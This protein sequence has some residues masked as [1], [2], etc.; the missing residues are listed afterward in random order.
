LTFYNAVTAIY[1][2]W[3][4]GWTYK[5]IN[6]I[7]CSV[8]LNMSNGGHT[9]QS[10]NSVTFIDSS[11]TNTPV[12]I[13]TAFDATSLPPTSGS[14]IIENV[15]LN[16]VPIAIQGPGSA[17]VLSGST[18][19][20]TIAAWGQGHAYTPTGPT[21]FEG[22]V[23][24][25]PRPDS[26]LAGNKF[27][28]R[29][30]PQYAEVPVSQFLSVRDYGATGDG[31]TD[32]SEALNAILVTAAM[33]GKIV[34]FDAGIY[35]VKSTVGVPAGSRIVGES[36]PLI[37]GAGAFFSDMNNPQP[38]V[39]VGQ[40]GGESGDAVEW[41]D[42]IVAT[43]GATA[44]AVLIEWNL[45]ACESVPSGMWDVHTRIGGF[46]GSDLQ[47]TQ[48]QNTPSQNV[49]S[50]AA[51]NA[52]C[53]AAFMSMHVTKGAARL[54]LE[55]VWLWTADHDIDDPALRRVTIYAG[56]GLYIESDNGD[57]WL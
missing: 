8:G 11:I 12:G 17:T 40:E 6:I 45:D 10:V 55:N 29:S 26:I 27:Y 9:S 2:L 5:S 56:R 32:D 1:Q 7:N 30:K 20:L 19:S 53:I 34:F 41:S 13:I 47:V 42:M 44:G 49:T 51:V 3:D 36:Y 50:L 43:K 21:D 57:L 4:W 37:M 16:N 46:R 35:L 39:R 54:Y 33:A 22:P 52:N 18:G 48:C 14:L 24:P 15:Q 31:V 25:F 28:E 23:A 38:V